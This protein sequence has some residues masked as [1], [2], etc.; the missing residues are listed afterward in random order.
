MGQLDED[1]LFEECRNLGDTILPYGL[2]WMEKYTGM[3]TTSFRAHVW[4]TFIYMDLGSFLYWFL[5]TQF[6]LE[7][8]QDFLSNFWSSRCGVVLLS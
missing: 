3:E 2:V 1:T 5:H 4:D 7:Y 6:S 8:S